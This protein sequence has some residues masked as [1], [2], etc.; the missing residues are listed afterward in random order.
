MFRFLR[1]AVGIPIVAGLVT[2]P[3][4]LS[5]T[6]AASSNVPMIVKLRADPGAVY[7]AKLHDQGAAVSSDQVQTYE[8]GLK[9]AHDRLLT[10]S[11]ALYG[12]SR[13]E[14]L[15]SSEGSTGTSGMSPSVSSTT[16]LVYQLTY[17]P[18][19]RSVTVRLIGQ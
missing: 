14:V 4:L 5:G 12:T 16:T 6:E 7:A 17:N 10:Q 15:S 13:A 8:Q 1:I 19:L 11:I 9:T 18:L 2:L 3:F